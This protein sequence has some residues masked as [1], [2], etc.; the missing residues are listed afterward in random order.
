MRRDLAVLTRRAPAMRDPASLL[1]ASLFAATLLSGCSS[2]EHSNPLDPRNGQTGGRP[3]GFAA[4]AFSNQV[5]L[6]WTPSALSTQIFRESELESDFTAISAVLPP[7]TSS[8]LDINAP[9]GLTFHYRLVF[10][11][12]HGLSAPSTADATPS[13]VIAYVADGGL[14]SILRLSA[15]GREV[16]TQQPGFGETTFVTIDRDRDQVWVANFNES[17]VSVYTPALGSKVV[18]P[19]T[20]TPEAIAI[21]PRDGSA[22]ITDTEGDKAWHYEAGGNPATPASIP[23]LDGP[24]GIDVDSTN[25]VIWIC[26]KTG[27]RVRRFSTVDASVLG[28]VPITA[29]SRVAVDSANGEAWIT[30]FDTAR[31]FHVSAAGGIL[32]TIA[33]FRGPVGV[34]VDPRRG[35]IWVADPAASQV[36]AFGRDGT[37]QLRVSNL[38][39]ARDLAVELSSGEAWVALRSTIA[40]ISPTGAVLAT[41]RGLSSPAGVALDLLA[42]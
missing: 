9:N 29:P 2:R 17:I 22:W 6:R 26:E 39:E 13:R 24:I 4:V 31:L 3:A 30:S 16:A 40:R 18:I 12:D 21:D 25:R 5:L 10:V 7:G 14:G 37:E 27:N 38:T 19:G 28:Q 23:N 34:A 1:V 32:H 33:A 35:R 42:R 15:D 41:T 36:I 20:T 8:F 11:T